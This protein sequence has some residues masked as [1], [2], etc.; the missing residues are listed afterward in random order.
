LRSVRWAIAELESALGIYRKL[1]LGRGLTFGLVI[2]LA[3]LGAVL[4]AL[5]ISLVMPLV[6]KIDG[7][8]P[9][10]TLWELLPRG[11][12]DATLSQL[13]LLVL[14]VFVGKNA[15]ALARI[16]FSVVFL[17]GLWRRWVAR[18]IDRL[19]YEDDAL[20]G[21]A[22]PGEVVSITVSESK[23][24]AN[25]MLNLVLLFVSCFTFLSVYAVLWM[26]SW[27][28]TLALTFV[29]LFLAVT[30][31]R[32]MT[33]F[34]HRAGRK[35]VESSERVS[36]LLIETV[37]GRRDI[38][39]LGREDF[40]ESRLEEP[41]VSVQTSLI[42]MQWLSSVLQ[43]LIETTAVVVFC[44]AVLV[45]TIDS[46]GLLNLPLLGVF[47]A[48][49]FRL[50]PVLNVVGAQWVTVIS[51]QSAAR[52][53][54][55]LMTS[56]T[57]A[58]A[59]P[60]SQRE[61]PPIS[62]GVAYR[63]V[64]YHY[65]ERAHVL[66]EF[67]YFLAAGHRVALVGESGA[68]KS[69]VVSLLMGFQ[70]PDSG[71]IELDGEALDD[72]TLRSFRAQVGYVG[73]ESTLFN[74]TLEENIAFGR[75]AASGELVREV[76][77]VVGVDSLAATLPDGYQTSLGERGFSLSG[78][79]RQRVL[80]ARALLSRPRLL[81][82]DEAFSALDNESASRL[83][84]DVR[85]FIPS[86]TWLLVSHRI[87]PVVDFDDIVIMKDGRLL[88][89]GTHRELLETGELYPRLLDLER[90]ANEGRSTP[91][92]RLSPGTP[93]SSVVSKADGSG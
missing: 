91:A 14:A 10:G 79:Q 59:R 9:G 73:Q 17:N 36:S 31:L 32:T 46:G 57:E 67:S 45:S 15:V 53:V 83:L 25:S 55:R 37:S 13:A 20:P 60:A 65:P 74:A 28:A 21:G 52:R 92:P 11:I 22:D 85:K 33:G 30:G 6:A 40:F 62:R 64:S 38:R 18:I 93:R 1:L 75:T 84:S 72:E 58:R 16:R 70:S 39:A 19:L 3:L 5:G 2:A 71:H 87:G 76:A 80:L 68:G 24:T 23:D 78:G 12:R 77:R 88:E 43:P 63:N 82:L 44:G 29:F 54:L 27:R 56:P 48:A 35:L 47:A 66:H 50:F 61:V 34:A 51:R 41:T 86:A 7:A 4:D 8:E 69:T 89:H 90:A 49:A 42:S 26:S 81:V